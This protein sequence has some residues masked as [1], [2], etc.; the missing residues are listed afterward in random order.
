MSRQLVIIIIILTDFLTFN[1][2]CVLNKVPARN[3]HILYMLT[4]FQGQFPEVQN[5]FHDWN[6]L[7]NLKPTIV[8]SLC[9]FMRNFFKRK[10]LIAFKN[11][12]QI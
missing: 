12:D 6:K 8:Q 1:K 10:I 2:F 7:A 4:R 9:L 3:R 5:I 11:F